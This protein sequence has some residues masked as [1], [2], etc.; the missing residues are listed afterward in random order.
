MSRISHLFCLTTGFFVYLCCHLA[1]RMAGF[2]KDPGV[3]WHIASGNWILDNRAVPLFDPFLAHPVPLPWVSDQWGSDLLLA[4]VFRFLGWVGLY[5]LVFLIYL[6]AFFLV[7][8][9]TVKRRTGSSFIAL[10]VTIFTSKPAEIHFILRPV[11]GGFLFMALL[12]AMLPSA[13]ASTEQ[14]RLTILFNTFFLFFIWANCH[15]SFA[16]GLVILGLYVVTAVGWDCFVSGERGALV[17]GGAILLA[18]LAGTLCNPYG[19]GLHRSILTLGSSKFFM[20]LH[21]EWMPLDVLEPE[22]GFFVWFIG[23]MVVAG[24]I[25]ASR[26]EKLNG[27]VVAELVILAFAAR[28]GLAHLRMVP[29][30]FILSAPLLGSSVLVL[31]DCLERRISSHVPGLRAR[32]ERRERSE[33]ERASPRGLMALLS[34]VCVGGSFFGRVA[35]F[36]TIIPNPEGAILA[37]RGEVE[38]VFQ[39]PLGPPV[40]SYPYQ[41][42]AYLTTAAAPLSPLGGE[43]KKE[44]SVLNPPDWGGF[45]TLNGSSVIRP[46]FDDRNTLLGEARYLDYFRAA[47]SCGTLMKLAKKSGADFLM[48]RASDLTMEGCEVTTLSES[49][50]KEDIHQVAEASSGCDGEGLCWAESIRL[51]KPIYRDRVAAVFRVPKYPIEEEF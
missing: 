34:L 9:P 32:F 35:G 15:P 51:L 10:V 50:R 17:R 37:D 39:I 26:G 24:L 30:F 21:Q 23:I 33:S 19:W 49:Q 4:V 46:L 44:F 12:G 48:V 31:A 43:A 28:S 45:I 7:V 42:V 16:Y 14:K 8:Y 1:S 29:Y 20:R 36:P 47:R 27:S 6:S 2:A 5:N 18:A 25:R 22:G 41:A 40:S 13:A 3:G 11:V 38:R